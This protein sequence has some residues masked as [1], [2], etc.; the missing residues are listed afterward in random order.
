MTKLLW[1]TKVEV[2]QFYL[3]INVRKVLVKPP[4]WSKINSFQTTVF[5]ILTKRG[6]DW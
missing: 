6:R 3:N 5:S 4:K 1:C 2:V